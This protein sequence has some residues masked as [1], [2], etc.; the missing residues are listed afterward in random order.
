LRNEGNT[1]GAS[2]ESGTNTATGDFSSRAQPGGTMLAARWRQ[3]MPKTVQ[4][5]LARQLSDSVDRLQKQAET[6][7]FWATALS[8]FA[9]PVPD[10]DPETT[11]VARY[12]KPGH[13]ARKRHRR[14]STSRKQASAKP[15]SA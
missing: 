4:Q 6:V 9:Q 8:G 10:Y 12:V 7:E 14:R 13:P 1:R 5:T 11:A 15:A 3:A 2:L